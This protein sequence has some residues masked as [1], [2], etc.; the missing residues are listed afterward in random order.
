MCDAF[1]RINQGLELG[2]VLPEGLDTARSLAGAHSAVITTL[3]ES[4]E[5]EDFLDSNKTP[6]EAKLS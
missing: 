5:I 6:D 3:N 1:G 4:G 2:D